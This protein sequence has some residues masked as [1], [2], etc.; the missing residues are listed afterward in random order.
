LI[1]EVDPKFDRF[2]RYE[3]YIVPQEKYLTASNRIVFKEFDLYFPSQYE[4]V[5]KNSIDPKVCRFSGLGIGKLVI[6]SGDI[7]S[8]EKYKNQKKTNT[9]YAAIEVLG[10]CSVLNG[11]H[12][13]LHITTFG[14][15]LSQNDSIQFLKSDVLKIDEFKLHHF[16]F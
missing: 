6:C 2:D 9:M 16:F 8:V 14:V 11:E 5:Q 10:N 12:I 3:P 4:V 7:L 13:I 15:S 1:V